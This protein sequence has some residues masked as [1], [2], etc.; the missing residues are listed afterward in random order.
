MVEGRVLAGAISLYARSRLFYFVSNLD[1]SS[2][3][4][5]SLSTIPTQF[6]HLIAK[7]LFHLVQSE[8][9]SRVKLFLLR[10][11]NTWPAFTDSV[12]EDFSFWPFVDPAW[13]SADLNVQRDVQSQAKTGKRFMLTMSECENSVCTVL[14][15][16]H[17]SSCGAKLIKSKSSQFF[18]TSHSKNS[19]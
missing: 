8:Y 7:N 5:S 9:L 12:N 10:C 18:I 1:F 19:M 3:C 4:T 14:R 15:P 11:K 2:P 16:T 13:F 6:A 17:S